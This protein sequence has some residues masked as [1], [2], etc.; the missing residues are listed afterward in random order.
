LTIAWLYFPNNPLY[1]FA[2]R[3]VLVGYQMNRR[4]ALALAFVLFL[5]GIAAADSR[6]LEFVKE[7]GPATRPAGWMSVVS[8]SPDGARVAANGQ[9]MPDGSGN[10]AIWSF[11]EGRL[12]NHLSIDPWTISPNWKYYAATWGV[13]E[14]NPFKVLVSGLSYP[15]TAFSPDD[16]YV[17]AS[18]RGGGNARGSIRIFE[19]ASGR[20]VR[21]FGRLSPGALA[22]SPD[23]HTLAAGY[24]DIITLW[25]MR[26]GK[27]L[28]VLRGFGRYVSGI[29]FIPDGKLLA[30]GTDFGSVRIWDLMRQG[31]IHELKIG[32]GYVSTPAFSPDGRLVAVGIYGTGTVFL[33][34]TEDGKLLDQQKVSDLGCGSVAFSPDG[35]FLITPSTG[36]LIKW[37]YDHGGTIRVFRVNV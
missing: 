29:S 10:V 1:I 31:K 20:Q 15:A 34:S 32:G 17:A 21:A 18:A 33:M 9:G 30:A 5:P 25:D 6:P 24:W 35:R 28:S 11:P 2:E 12:I 8:F 13:G 16:R 7:I 14:I 19:L 27:R 26:T 22:I 36:G 3:M 4:I 23:G 37:P